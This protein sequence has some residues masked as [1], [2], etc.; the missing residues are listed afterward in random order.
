MGT[1]ERAWV[2][3]VLDTGTGPFRGSCRI[4]TAEELRGNVLLEEAASRCVLKRHRFILRDVFG[5][6]D[7]TIVLGRNI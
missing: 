3:A 6:G 4:F 2:S 7:G 5:G 1:P